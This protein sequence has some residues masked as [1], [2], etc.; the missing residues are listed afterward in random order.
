[1]T[2]QGQ[3]QVQCL[4]HYPCVILS[5]GALTETRHSVITGIPVSP[6]LMSWSSPNYAVLSTD[7]FLSG[8]WRSLSYSLSFQLLLL[9]AKPSTEKKASVLPYM[10]FLRHLPKPNLYKH[11]HQMDGCNPSGT[12]PS[13]DISPSRPFFFNIVQVPFMAWDDLRLHNPLP[14]LPPPHKWP[15]IIS[16]RKPTN[17]KLLDKME[18]KLWEQVS[19]LHS[20]WIIDGN[21]IKEHLMPHEIGFNEDALTELK[22]AG[23]S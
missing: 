3:K 20:M 6:A 19:W 5:F 22:K 10:K 17:S 13:R 7:H 11:H 15:G 12:S 8:T 18:M 14:T 23:S 4:F 21:R 1:M 9:L 2:I 16:L